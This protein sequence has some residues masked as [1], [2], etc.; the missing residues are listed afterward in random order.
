MDGAGLADAPD[1]QV[2]I[3]G[4]RAL[5]VPGRRHRDVEALGQRAHLVGGIGTDRAATDDDHRALRGGEYVDRAP[6]GLRVG[7]LQ[8]DRQPTSKVV[9]V[10][11]GGLG[12]QI[13]RHLDMG[14]AAASRSASC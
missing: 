12:V 8:A 3:L 5:A 7:V 11:L 10:H 14:R 6:D 4:K 13:P 2:V 1:E 9:E